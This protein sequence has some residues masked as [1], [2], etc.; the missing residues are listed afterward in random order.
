MEKLLE[1]SSLYLSSLAAPHKRYF[2]DHVDW[3]DKL[4]GLIGAR[5]VGKTTFILNYLKNLDIPLSKKLYISADSIDAVGNSLIEI[6]K[7]FE[8]MGG[9]ILAIDEIHKY[10]NFEIELK[11][12]YDMLP[13]KVIFS[14]SSA[15]NLEHK[16]ADL[17][18]R[19]V[20]YRID[21][22]SFREFIE[23]KTDKTLPSFTIETLLHHHTEIADEIKQSVKP[24][25]YWDEYVMFGYYPFYFENPKKY[26]LK[27]N[28]TINTVIEV[29]I[30][31]IFSIKYE[32]ISNLKKLVKYICSSEPFKL[33][34]KELSGKIGIDRDTLYQYLE[35]LNR[36][37]ILRV[38]R[39][40]SKGD[41][42]FVKPSKI[43]LNNAN[44]NHS[45]CDRASKG[46]IRET[47]FASLL[48]N[49]HEI[50]VAKNGDFIIDDRYTFE[51]GGKNKSYKQIKDIDNSFVVADDIEIGFGNKIPLWLFGFL[52]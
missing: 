52:Y 21:G 37:K 49:A 2:Y 46:M 22:L 8:A 42:I 4:V 31:S 28:E 15:V 39:P 45:Y 27:L 16:K 6:A 3:D 13:L 40:K 38:I 25:E 11:Q 35:Y 29:D 43:Y 34:I 51:I 32:N 7:K 10:R 48:S 41:G 47:L 9:K 12:I 36:G 44:L 14:G 50:S 24:F 17:S 33:N 18:R 23:F 5:G 1:N 19:A 20:I 30:P 26:A